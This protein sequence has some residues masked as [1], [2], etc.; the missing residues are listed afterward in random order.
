MGSYKTICEAAMAELIIKKSRF[1]AVLTPITKL[2]D[3][4]RELYDARQKYPKANHYC[5]AFILRQDGSTLERC[6]DDGE[7]GGT[8]GLPLLN[9]LNKRELKNIMAIVIRY[10]GGTLLGTGGLVKAYTQAI[11]SALEAAKLVTIEYAQN[12]LI[13]FPYTYYNSFKHSFYD[14]M[15]QITNIEFSD[16]VAIKMWIAADKLDNF[17]EKASQITGGT[18]TIEYL[19]KDFIPH[20]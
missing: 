19:S 18:A 9:V 15:N 4:D 5:H 3:I 10:F 6:S 2:Q 17:I 20:V 16:V 14:L 8:A 7:P 11:Q 1:I 13:R 12:V